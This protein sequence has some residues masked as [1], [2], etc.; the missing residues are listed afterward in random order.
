MG[1]AG[2]CYELTA[3]VLE[4]GGIGCGEGQTAM[5][6]RECYRSLSCNIK[7]ILWLYDDLDFKVE[8]S[9][10]ADDGE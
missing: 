10:G 7:F 1:E 6:T 4:G 9:S 5:C 2:S 3:K 8:A